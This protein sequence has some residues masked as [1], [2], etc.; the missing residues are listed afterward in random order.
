[1]RAKW[2]DLRELMAGLGA[3]SAIVHE[4]PADAV[5]YRLALSKVARDA[6]LAANM[7]VALGGWE[8]RPEE[9]AVEGRG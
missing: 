3:L 1:M 4:L 6:Q 9:V 7:A 5:T 8:P 2:S